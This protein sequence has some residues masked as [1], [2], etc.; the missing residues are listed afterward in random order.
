MKNEPNNETAYSRISV[1]SQTVLP[2]QVREVLAV[3]PGDTLRYRITPMGVII[4]KAPPQV[5]DPFASFTE[6]SGGA[7][8]E[9]Y[10]DL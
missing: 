4:D 1:K 10:G 5:D 3:V 6:W 8:E 2:R 7:D 9:V